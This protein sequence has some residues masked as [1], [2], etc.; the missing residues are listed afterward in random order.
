MK[1]REIQ[2]E[3]YI[4]IKELHKKYNLRILNKEEWTKFW[5][6]NPCLLTSDN[7][8]PFGWVLEDNK[9]RIVAS[10]GNIPK[11][12]YYKNK[13]FVIACSHAWIAEDK[14]R[15]EAFSLLNS[16]FSQKNID[17]FMVT[18][19]NNISAKIFT[20][21]NAKKMPLQNYQ[22][23]MFVILDLEKLIYSFLKYKKLPFEKMIG[24]LVFYLSSIIFYKKLTFWK[25]IHQSKKVT[26]NE[27]IDSKFDEF[28][29]TYKLDFQ[30]K[31]L[32]SRT[33]SWVKW[34]IQKNIESGK[35]WIMSVIE[36]NKLLGYAIC[37]ERNN[38]KIELKRITLIDLVSLKD[39]EEVYFSLIKNCIIETKK[40]GYHMFEIVGF[41][42]SKRKIFS[43]FQTFS[44]NLSIFPFYYKTSNNVNENFLEIKDTWDPSLID[45]DSFL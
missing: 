29:N 11:E 39:N 28:W 10:L 18:S 2:I 16:F 6:E 37:L 19:A 13:K 25:K 32:Q 4:Q 17:I 1:I 31:F 5:I 9:K 3:D 21:Y 30:D 24:K 8:F 42:D 36:N 33:T 34:H 12:Y 26:L 35:A 40:R 22:N 7:P 43:K 23:S 41:K 27:I 20:R 14:Y 38:D 45:G 44:R 15:L